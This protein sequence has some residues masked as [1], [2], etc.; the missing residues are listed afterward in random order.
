MIFSLIN[1]SQL[2]I[3]HETQ[4]A[5]V[6][7][8]F[9]LIIQGTEKTL[10]MVSTYSA[11]HQHLFEL[12][13]HTLWSCTHGGDTSLMVIDV[14]SIEAVVAMVPHQPFPDLPESMLMSSEYAYVI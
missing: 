2:Y 9:R 5:E 13:H 7:Y 8:Y 3:R 4:F 12:S 14:K 10:A 11:P 1:I 6:Y